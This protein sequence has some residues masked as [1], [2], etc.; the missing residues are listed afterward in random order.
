MLKFENKAN[1]RYYYVIVKRDIL[2]DLVLT[3][4]RGSCKQR[5]EFSRGGFNADDMQQEI[6]RITKRRL[7]RGY[8]II[9]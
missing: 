7:Q 4:I 9:N 3:I 1:G 6:K 8:E 5:R 2:N